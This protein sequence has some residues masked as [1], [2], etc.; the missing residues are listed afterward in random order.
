MVLTELFVYID[1]NIRE[2]HAYTALTQT[3]SECLT[4]CY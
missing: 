2:L 3:I 1:M 4:H